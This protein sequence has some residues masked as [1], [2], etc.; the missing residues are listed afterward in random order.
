MNII[1]LP[2]LWA[3]KRSRDDDPGF[4]A[5]TPRAL[6][7]T[8]NLEPDFCLRS[9]IPLYSHAIAHGM[10]PKSPVAVTEPNIVFV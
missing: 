1:C 8:E 7:R 6:T 10:A 5:L 3:A 4:V 9:L 2:V